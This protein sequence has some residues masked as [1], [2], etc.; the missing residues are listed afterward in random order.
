MLLNLKRR[1]RGQ[2][3]AIDFMVSLLLF[4]L[5]LS[6]LILVIVNVQ[7][8]LNSQM[9]DDLSFTELDIFGRS[10][11]QEEGTPQWGY[12]QDLPSSFGLAESSTFPS[13]TLDA[14]KIAR[15]ITGTTF[16]I[17]AVSGF[18]QFS[19]D[20]VKSLLSLGADQE[21][22]LSILP[23]LDISMVIT[24]KNESAYQNTVAITNVNNLP[25]KESYVSFFTLDLTTGS[26]VLAGVDISDS[27]GIASNEY[28]DPN[29]NVPEG[30]HLSIVIAEKGP[31]WGIT[32]GNPTSNPEDILIGRESNATI[33][34]CGLSSSSLLISDVHEVVG[35]PDEHFLSYIYKNNQGNFSIESIALTS[36]FEANETI[37]IPKN[38]IVA[39]FSII[40]HD[41]KYKVGIGTFPAVLNNNQNSGNF[42]NV[43][44]KVEE[45]SREKTRISKD[46][47]VYIRGTLMKCRIILWRV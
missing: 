22:Q 17:S 20:S 5:M 13:L 23:L 8:G 19:Y 15:L 10:L 35:T 27:D 26:I 44:G 2:V 41:D 47:P 42:Y 12:K 43:F 38:G 18:E 32:W 40:K 4:L 39:F 45:N 6:Q 28:I 31:L 29:F 46:F 37:S 34:A 24:E 9:K 21:F 33:W 1:R 30:E 7:T 16:P 36:M 3:R 11:L 25:S 14:S